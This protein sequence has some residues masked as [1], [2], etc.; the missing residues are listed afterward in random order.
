MNTERRTG[1][2]R[3]LSVRAVENDCANIWVSPG[4]RK[5]FPPAAGESPRQGEVRYTV[6]FRSLLFNLWMP[7]SASLNVFRSPDFSASSRFSLS[8]LISAFT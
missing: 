5:G 7:W 3:T 2:E 1:K 6:A 8:A 4:S